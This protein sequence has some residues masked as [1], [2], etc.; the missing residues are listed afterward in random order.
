MVWNGLGF[1]FIVHRSKERAEPFLDSA[2][3]LGFALP[4]NWACG[5]PLSTGCAQTAS[6]AFLIEGLFRLGGH[7]PKH[8]FDVLL[9]G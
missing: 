6:M 5:I 9:D 3:D 2:A 1:P 8:C 4:R 7:L